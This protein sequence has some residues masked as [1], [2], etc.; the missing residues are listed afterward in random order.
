[1]WGETGK[2]P[3][4]SKKTNGT[5]WRQVTDKNEI[6]INPANWAKKIRED[7]AGGRGGKS[8]G[9]GT[10]G[11]GDGGGPSTSGEVVRAG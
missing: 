2:T 11:L 3:R 8:S 10:P 5:K 6:N 7:M 9:N 4:L 1:L